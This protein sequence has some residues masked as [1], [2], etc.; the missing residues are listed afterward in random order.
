[1]HRWSREKKRTRRALPNTLISGQ[2]RHFE[3]FG[4]AAAEA[5]DQAGYQLRSMGDG[6]R[7]PGRGAML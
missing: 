7:W 4:G 3:G 2:M 6:A 5:M 1:M